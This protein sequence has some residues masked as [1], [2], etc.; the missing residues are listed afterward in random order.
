MASDPAWQ[1]HLR[2]E[3]RSF[4]G[5][6]SFKRDA[7]GSPEPS[8]AHPCIA[9]P[10]CHQLLLS[11]SVRH[12]PQ[13]VLKQTQLQ[14]VQPVQTA[15][16]WS[17]SKSAASDS[18]SRKEVQFWVVC[19]RRGRGVISRAHAR[20][21]EGPQAQP[22]P[23][24]GGGAGGRRPHPVWQPQGVPCKGSPQ[25]KGTGIHTLLQL[26]VWLHPG[27]LGIEQCL[28]YMKLHA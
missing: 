28:L 23:T 1:E 25:S 17:T 4:T 10:P 3:T 27:W 19:S 15:T 6:Q 26:Q 11:S 8:G 18:L 13:P 24:G 12:R 7:N 16:A 20:E 14:Q 2:S 22:K 5:A 21:A 9:A